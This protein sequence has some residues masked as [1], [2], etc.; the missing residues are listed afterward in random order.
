MTVQIFHHTVI[1]H[2]CQLIIRKMYCKEKII[3]FISIVVWIRIHSLFS[4]Q[5]CCCCTM[6][7]IGNIS[8]FDICKMAND[9]L[10]CSIVFDYPKGMSDTVIS[11]KIIFRL[12]LNDPV[13]DFVERN[14]FRISEKYRF[15]IHTTYPDMFLSVLFL[16][17]TC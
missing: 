2:D 16:I 11:N 15:I 9:S 8:C 5:S 6:M 14:H 10:N 17:G 1:I 3:F 13:Y 12:T 4:N 7:T